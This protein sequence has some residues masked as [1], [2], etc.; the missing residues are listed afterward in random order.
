MD[1]IIRTTLA[2]FII[3]L[4]AFTGIVT[5]NAYVDNAY[6]NTFTGTYSYTCTITTDAPLYNVTLFI[7]VPVDNTG[8]SPMVSEFSSN[9]MKGVPAEWKTT[10]FDTGKSTLL[11]VMTP[12]I[13][14]PNG[15]TASRPYTITFSSETASRSPID[16]RNPV[17]KS[18]MFR[19]VQALSENACPQEHA[20]GSSQCFTYTTSLYA[21]YVTAADT[22]VT[23]TSAVTGKNSWTI[24][25]P[26]SNEYQTDI[27]TSMRGENH[28][29]VVPDGKLSSG[30]GTY[31]IPAGA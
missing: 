26:R 19:P 20:D 7:P 2:L 4:A 5:Y 11:K 29:W 13:V 8:N 14:P 3:I 28:G 27:S 21:D 10:L 6:R 22:T 9:M 16:T 1:K 25:E 30:A 31:D 17:E 23:I 18:A 12:A 15:T 24:F